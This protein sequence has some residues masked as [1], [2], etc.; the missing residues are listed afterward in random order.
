MIVVAMK[1]MVKMG[2]IVIVIV[3]K[4]GDDS[5]GDAG[6]KDAGDGYNGTSD[7]WS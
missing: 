4:D 5:G 6:N 3:L 1:I 2:L 7:A